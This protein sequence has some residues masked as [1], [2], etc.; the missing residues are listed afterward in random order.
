MTESERVSDGA[1]RAFAEAAARLDR[2]LALRP[3]DPAPLYLAGVT[4]HAQGRLALARRRLRGAFAVVPH[5]PE[6]AFALGNLYLD[7]GE[8]G[9]AER[10]FRR[11]LAHSP[12]FGLCRQALAQALVSQGRHDSA[13][14]ELRAVLRL[15]PHAAEA[16]L[17]LAALRLARDD[18]EAARPLLRRAASTAPVL[19][20]VHFLLADL[21]RREG[22]APSS[23]GA[24]RRALALDPQNAP[25]RQGLGLV[26]STLGVSAPALRHLRTAL[27][28]SPAADASWFA[29]AEGARSAHDWHSSVDALRRTIACA[30]GR[31]DALIHL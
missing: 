11:A 14:G 26:L 19:S 15:D 13:E 27:V 31:T 24:Y 29:L 2:V 25:A 9:A 10:C 8:A 30:P 3:G 22:L 7:L 1:D 20:R 17:A 28:L 23:A 21:A 16:S 12:G 5:A 18:I 6:I 4:A